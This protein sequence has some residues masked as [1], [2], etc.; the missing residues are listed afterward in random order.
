MRFIFY[1]TYSWESKF[2]IKK[3]E[4]KVGQKVGQPRNLKVKRKEKIRVKSC[5]FHQSKQFRLYMSHFFSHFR[6][7]KCWFS[8]I[9]RTKNE[10]HIF[11]ENENTLTWNV[12]K[13]ST[14]IQFGCLNLRKFVPFFEIKGI[15]I[16]SNIFRVSIGCV[17]LTFK[18]KWNITL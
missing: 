8:A 5:E 12:S 9:R 18:K 6:F 10:S 3:L 14:L 7:E 4:K 17:V 15:L 2:W 13:M 16:L 11:C 1:S